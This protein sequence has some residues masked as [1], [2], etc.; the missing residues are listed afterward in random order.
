M[1]R[2]SSRCNTRDVASGNIADDAAMSL[3]GSSGSSVGVAEGL[4]G[5]RNGS[6]CRARENG[7]TAVGDTG[8]ERRGKRSNGACHA[9]RC[10][11]H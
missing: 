7:E 8:L 11:Y 4:V 1:S 5:W 6:R 2:A 3:F 9:T 10:C